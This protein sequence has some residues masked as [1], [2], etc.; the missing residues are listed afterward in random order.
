[1]KHYKL[2]HA[3]A[4]AWI[5]LCRPGSIIGPQ[6]HFLQQMEAKMWAAGEKEGLHD[7]LP[8]FYTQS[9]FISLSQLSISSPQYYTSCSES[10]FSCSKFEKDF[11][12]LL[13]VFYY[14]V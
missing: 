7:K 3:E 4:I 1:M 14:I 13:K 12:C 6:Q 10:I 8:K 2:T 9:T 11:A 5:R